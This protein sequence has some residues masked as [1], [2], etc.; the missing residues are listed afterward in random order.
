MKTI[1]REFEEQHRAS[2]RKILEG[3][4]EW[5]GIP[6]AN[7]AYISALGQ[8]PTAVAMI[9]Q[10]VIGFCALEQHN[11]TSVELHVIAI[12]LNDHN[13]GIGSM[14]VGWA[15]SRCRESGAK[16]FHV[17]TR[18]PS[19]PDPHYASTRE[20][21]LAKGF[22]VLFESL[23]LWGPEDAALVMVKKINA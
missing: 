18:G 2:C 16:W 14:L 10:R 8:L 12:D 4:P 23:T 5:F 22:D 20:F 3:L 1:I 15:E 6:S 17:K 9:D 11:D 21:Y 13:Q 19:T 7:T